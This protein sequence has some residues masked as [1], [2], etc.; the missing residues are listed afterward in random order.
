MKTRSLTYLC[1]ISSS[2][3]FFRVCLRQLFASRKTNCI[4]NSAFSGAWKL[5]LKNVGGDEERVSTVFDEDTVSVAQLI[6]PAV[7][8]WQKWVSHLPSI[9]SALRSPI[10]CGPVDGTLICHCRMLG[11]YMSH[12]P[13]EDCVDVKKDNLRALWKQ[14]Y[15]NSSRKM[16]IPVLCHLGFLL[17]TKTLF[18][19]PRGHL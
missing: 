9:T 10:A 1:F 13:T 11:R 6:V 8:S 14:H 2:L 12:E 18:T 15:W 5:P 19:D 3:L 7:D 4:L 17:R 16:S